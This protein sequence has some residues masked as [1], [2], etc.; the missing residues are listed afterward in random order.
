MANWFTTETTTG[1]RTL[2]S[3]TAGLE[4]L[5]KNIRTLQTREDLSVLDIGCAEG[6]IGD[7]LTMGKAKKL[8]GMEGDKI[9][10][11]SAAQ[12]YSD[13]INENRYR[14]IRANVQ[15]LAAVCRYN[16]IQDKFDIVLLLAILQKLGDPMPC[17][18]QAVSMADKFVAIRAPQYF[19]DQHTERIDQIMQG[20]DLMYQIIETELD[21]DYVG[22]LRVY[23]RPTVEKKLNVI[24]A[25]MRSISKS[26]FLATCDYPIVSFPKSGRT[27]I[28]Y[29]LGRYLNIEHS[30]PMD[31]EFMP[32]P[33]WTEERQSLDFPKI[34]FTHDWFDLNHSDRRT[35]GVF[36]KD[37]L[38]KKP[39]IFLLRNPMDTI[40]SYYY[41]KVKREKSV[42]S[43]ELDLTRF[44]LDERYGLGRYCAWIDAMLDYMAA[45]SNTM[46]LT[47]EDMIADMP[48]EMNR[49]FD[50]MKIRGHRQG[51]ISAAADSDF[52]NMQRAEVAANRDPNV[53]GIGRLGMKDWSGDWD[54][55]KVRKGKI[56]SWMD[57]PALDENYMNKLVAGDDRIK[58]TFN[59][60]GRR[61]PQCMTG[62]KQFVK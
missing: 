10:V 57:E 45:R 39:M 42:S 60:L 47:Y 51:I 62:L 23:A 5:Q 4:L 29:F 54:Q 26:E 14:F 28:R 49:M 21:A 19:W 53:V 9:K 27:W 33:Y 43:R 37:I 22:R 52:E 13:Q 58:V 24:R 56:G 32:Q 41:H 48:R 55:L 3:R 61:Y 8:L 50:F 25:E 38:D 16:N 7:W 2:E 40:V 44:I 15:D 20:W 17:L 31:L 35:P 34:H 6:L 11:E 30:M 18:E 36:Y 46:L 59:R 1:I 12:I